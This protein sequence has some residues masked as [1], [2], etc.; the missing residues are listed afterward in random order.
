MQLQRLVL[1]KRLKSNYSLTMDEIKQR[2]E[3]EILAKSDESATRR[4][5]ASEL[6]EMQIRLD[7]ETAKSSD[8]RYDLPFPR[9]IRPVA[10]RS[11]KQ[12]SL[13]AL[14]PKRARPHIGC[15]LRSLRIR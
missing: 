3:T 2:L 5:L 10:P 15:R 4:K 6:K 14:K 9:Q 8:L 12:Q 13:V 1:P 7:A 11:S